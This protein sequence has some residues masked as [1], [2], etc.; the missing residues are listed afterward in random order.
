M[1]KIGRNDPC[2][3]GSGKK[4]KKCH[5]GKEDEMVM[6]ATDEFSY[7]MSIRIT[8][9]PPVHYGRSKEMIEALDIKELTGSALGVRFIDLEAYQRL[10]LSGDPTSTEPKGGAGG[11]LV[12]KNKTLKSDED[13]VYVAISPLIGDSAL[14]HLL[15]HVLDHLGGSRIMP[16]LSKPLSY[17]LGI[18][19]E[20]LEHPNEFGYWLE[21]LSREF[22]VDLDADDTII[23]YLYKKGM[24]IKAEEIESQNRFLL[25][26]KSEAILKFLSERSEEID[27][28]ICERSGYIGS[29]VQ[30]E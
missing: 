5:L 1:K 2:P 18:P 11:V 10:N 23:S 21:Y 12:N 13:N 8:S 9:L 30:K 15:A 6:N 24:L 3:C 19:T 17:E 25:K 16:E 26:S 14:I 28:L 27:A 20:H 22:A 4:F 7:E 29:R